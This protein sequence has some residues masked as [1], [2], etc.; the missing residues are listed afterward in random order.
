MTVE[1]L[2]LYARKLKPGGV[3]LFHISNR[4]YD[5][6][7]ALAAS[8][9][10]AGFAGAL[11]HRVDGLATLE[12]VSRWFALARDPATL[13]PLLKVGWDDASIVPEADPWTDDHTNVLS[14]LELPAP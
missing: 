8:A 4:Y 11:K 3:L 7:P 10:A 2:E 9:R 1:A 14:A 5:L 12:L 6:A 13:A